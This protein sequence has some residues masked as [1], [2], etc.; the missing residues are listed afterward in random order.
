MD[1]ITQE[2]LLAIGLF[3]GPRDLAQFAMA[4][5]RHKIALLDSSEGTTA[6]VNSLWQ[7][8]LKRD[9]DDNL[10]LPKMFPPK[11]DI[12]ALGITTPVELQFY[13]AFYYS[14][15]A[16]HNEIT[17]WYRERDMAIGQSLMVKTVLERFF[18]IFRSKVVVVLD[19]HRCVNAVSQDP[20]T[21]L[22][23]EDGLCAVYLRGNNCD[24]RH[25]YWDDRLHQTHRNSNHPLTI[26]TD[27]EM[28]IEI[29][30]CLPQAGG[31]LL[32]LPPRSKFYQTDN[33][34]MYVKNEN[35][36]NDEINDDMINEYQSNN[37]ASDDY[38]S[39]FEDYDSDGND[40]ERSEWL[41]SSAQQLFLGNIM[42]LVSGAYPEL[43][44]DEEEEEDS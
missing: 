27:D 11:L 3:L 18:S 19:M 32:E 4:S 41:I 16:V 24:I 14:Y 21:M 40:Y 22:D 26:F 39:D 36:S 8:Q 20:K 43:L 6:F 44:S 25:H 13:R 38:E 12:T 1:Q 5:K 7:I 31:S 29:F 28:W 10:V 15:Y 2:L 35:C 42:G 9:N 23:A 17:R 30:I 33:Q 37:Y 34:P